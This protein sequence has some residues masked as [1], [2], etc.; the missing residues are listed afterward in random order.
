M[1]TRLLKV[2]EVAARLNLSRSL[3][4]ELVQRGDIRAV[5]IGRARRVPESEVARFVAVAMAKSDEEYR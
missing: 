4:Y 5:R 1:E 2:P 3:T